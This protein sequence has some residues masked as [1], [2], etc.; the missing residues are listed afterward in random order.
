MSAIVELDRILARRRQAFMGRTFVIG[1]TGGIAAGKST[2]GLELQH[3]ISR[4]PG[5]VR[6]ELVT[7]DGFLRDN[8]W[9][10]NAGLALRKGFPESY[11]TEALH[12]ALNAVRVGEAVFPGYSH[13]TYDI[14]HSLSR[15]L[16]R[17]DVLIIEGLRLVD[18]PVDVLIYIDA[19]EDDL[20]TWYVERFLDFWRAGRSDPNSFYSEFGHLTPNEAEAFGGRVWREV[21]LPNVR[22]HIAPLREVAD[23]VVH[24]AGDHSISRVVEGAKGVIE[25]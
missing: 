25:G 20:E 7:T 6:V 19:A 15:T 16:E 18:A 10:S 14:D 4:W 23:I 22:E 1:V 5:K 11:D 24:K 9:L 2:L 8:A 17:P 12:A 13:Y 21:N 3:R